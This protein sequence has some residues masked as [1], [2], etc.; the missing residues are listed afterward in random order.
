MYYDSTVARYLICVGQI[1]L[2]NVPLIRLL[3][4]EEVL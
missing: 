2:L 4:R 3:Y 1:V